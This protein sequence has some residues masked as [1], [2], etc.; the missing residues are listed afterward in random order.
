MVPMNKT[1]GAENATRRLSIWPITRQSPAAQFLSV[2][3]FGLVGVVLLG[4]ALTGGIVTP[5]V[6]G[7][8]GFYGLALL[9]ALFALRRSYP[10]PAI[11]FCNAVTLLRLMFVSA[12]IAG[13][14]TQSVG[15]WPVFGVAAVALALDGVDGWLARRE[16]Y[17]SDFGATFDMEVDAVLA[18][19]L[20]FHAYFGGSVGAYV[21]ILGLP[22]YLFLIAQF[23][24]PWL[25]ADLP[26]RF[27]RKVVC[28]LQISALIAVL[29]P[30]IQTPFS[31]AIVV[32]A[33]AA[34]I[35]SFWLDVRWLWQARP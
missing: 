23:P 10:H 17:V 3:L 22:R 31:D 21:I 18:L 8:T 14:V 4:G 26:P 16:G 29:L 30:V 20:A 9:V 7:A 1:P 19:V 33:A 35:W 34:V 11:G 12:L 25:K 28:V 27:S 15:P 6:L 24:L 13:L 5:G 32:F 2:G